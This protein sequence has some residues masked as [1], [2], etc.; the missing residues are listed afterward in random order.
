[1]TTLSQSR[2]IDAVLDSDC[3]LIMEVKRRSADGEDLMLGRTPT[4]LVELFERDRKSV[5]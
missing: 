5:V 2:F 4:E 1:M 3:P